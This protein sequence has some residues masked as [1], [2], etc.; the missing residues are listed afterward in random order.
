MMGAMYIPRPPILHL[1]VSDI[2]QNCSFESLSHNSAGRFQ[3]SAPRRSDDTLTPLS[4]SRLRAS[5]LRHC[6]FK[7][8][9]LLVC[10]VPLS[11]AQ[12]PDKIS[13]SESAAASP[14]TPNNFRG[15]TDEETT[16]S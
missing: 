12:S 14:M 15:E 16:D 2:S 1:L 6:L 3:E 5:P 9:N 7:Q 11:L 8:E 4:R 13:Q 10:R